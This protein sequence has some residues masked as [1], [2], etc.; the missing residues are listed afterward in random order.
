MKREPYRQVLRLAVPALGALAAEPMF[1]MVDSAIVGHLGV[2]PL[3]GLALA[4]MVIN[5]CVYLC[6]F[7]AY[8]TTAG[9][10]RAYGAGKLAD[11]A[12]QG[13]DSLWLGLGLGL[14]VAGGLFAAA[15]PICAALGAKGPVLD[16]AVAYLRWSAPGLP[17]ML[18]VLAATGVLRGL[19]NTR[20]TFHVAVVGGAVDAVLSFVLC[21]PA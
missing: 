2:A 11:A 8:A 21:Y 14:A 19:Q 15:K 18:A 9:V 5:T 4:G 20:I 12:R 13:I 1:V 16:A 3:A 17:A 7:L 10:A 6:V